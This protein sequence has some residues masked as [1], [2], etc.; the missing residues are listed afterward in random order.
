MHLSAALCL[1]FWY[2]GCTLLEEQ[3]AATVT[4]GKFP[5]ISVDVINSHCLLSRQGTERI[6]AVLVS[7]QRT[8]NRNGMLMQSRKSDELPH[9]LW[10]SLSG[11]MSLPKLCPAF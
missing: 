6:D 3:P 11:S 7:Q 1:A 5:A 10:R 2:R 8:N 4:L 9:S